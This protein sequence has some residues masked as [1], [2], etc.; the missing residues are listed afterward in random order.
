MKYQ[1]V[2]PISRWEAQAIFDEGTPQEIAF[3]LV[4]LAYYDPDWMW[5]QDTRITLSEH[6]DIG[7]KENQCN[8]FLATSQESTE[9]SKWKKSCQ[10]LIGYGGNPR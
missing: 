6:R 3:T 10:C 7:V 2:T 5:V 8:L 1:A 4:R 9:C